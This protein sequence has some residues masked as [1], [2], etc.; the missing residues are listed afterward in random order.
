M[1][2][3]LVCYYNYTKKKKMSIIKTTDHEKA[4]MSKAIYTKMCPHSDHIAFKTL[5]IHYIILYI[6]S[7]L[8]QKKLVLFNRQ[9]QL[10]IAYNII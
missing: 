5:S 3:I 2:F 8:P 7:L 6:V 1:R 4:H 9:L 10:Q